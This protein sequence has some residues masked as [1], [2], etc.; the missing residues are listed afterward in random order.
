MKIAVF[1]DM[2]LHR[3]VKSTDVQND[4][5]AFVICP[6]VGGSRIS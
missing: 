5:A 6:D 2:M 3:L 1:W 4:P